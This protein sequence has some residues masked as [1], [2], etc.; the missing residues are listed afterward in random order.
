MPGKKSI[1]FVFLH[2]FTVP[3]IHESRNQL[4]CDGV[5]SGLNNSL[6]SG[7]ALWKWLHLEH[8]P[9]VNA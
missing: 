6:M 9:M 8:N 7:T 1:V 4:I 5:S 3:F 2:H